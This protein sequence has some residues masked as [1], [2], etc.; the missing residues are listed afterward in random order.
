VPKELEGK[1]RSVSAFSPGVLGLTGIETAEILRG[2]VDKV[3]PSLL[4]C[5]D[6]LAAR[7]TSRIHAT[8][9]MSDT[10][11]SPGAGL[12]NRQTP[13]NQSTMGVPVVAIGVPT[14]L[15]LQICIPTNKTA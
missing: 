13:I 2:V 10:G 7:K 3:K 9:Q 5:V 14:V 4:I 15:M 6:A 1:L 8:I 11:V 12:G